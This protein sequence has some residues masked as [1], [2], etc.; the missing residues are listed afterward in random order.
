M[1]GRGGGVTHEG[2]KMA[3][4]RIEGGEGPGRAAKREKAWGGGKQNGKKKVCMDKVNTNLLYCDVW[5]RHTGDVHSLSLSRELRAPLKEKSSMG[6]V[7]LGRRGVK[8]V[9]ANRAGL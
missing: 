4:G 9:V 1:T 8:K 6:G 3:H 7:H 2:R 5:A